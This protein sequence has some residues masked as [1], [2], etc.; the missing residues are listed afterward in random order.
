CGS[1]V[2]PSYASPSSSWKCTTTGCRRSTRRR[3]RKRS[4]STTW[5][6]PPRASADSAR[7]GREEAEAVPVLPVVSVQALG[8]PAEGLTW[9][10]PTMRATVARLGFATI[11][12]V[13]LI[14][15]G[16]FAQG[17]DRKEK[18]KPPPKLKP[19]Q[20]D[21]QYGPHERNVLDLYLPKS[22]GPTP[23]VVY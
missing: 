3:P 14:G 13:T 11:L 10:G 15:L 6:S 21:V 22:G 20:A 16:D 1:A 17:Q 2:S 18:G 5:S 7:S 23:L 12:F 8:I 4:P 19:T 9:G